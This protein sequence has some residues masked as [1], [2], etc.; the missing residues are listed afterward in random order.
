MTTTVPVT[1]K[2]TTLAE[3]I[4]AHVRDGMTV[5]L[6]GFSH[7]I[8]FAAAHEIIRQGRRDLTLCRM[9]PDIVSDQL[10]AAGC[11]SKL[12]ASFFA[13]GSAGSLHELRRRIERHDPAPLEVEEYSHYGM[14]CRY[15]AGAAGLP[16]FPLRSYAGSDLPELNPRIRLTT[17]PYTGDSVYV[18][19]PLTPDVTIIHAQRADRAGN[20][21]VWGITGVQQEAVYAA[22]T[23]IVLVEEIVDD[24]VVRSDP[25]RTL[26]P[27]HAVDAIV[28]CPRG[29][30]PSYAQGY[31]DRDCAFYRNWTPISKD[32]AA[33]QNWIDE[34]I[35]GTR[36]HEEYL[37]RL[38]DDHWAGLAVGSR[39]SG[40]VD[41][42]SRL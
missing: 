13:S 10:V 16:F 20:V 6:E 3:A 32:P 39:P 23:A 22:R 42:G 37:A 30:H 2:V 24:E 1:D 27:A 31:Y 41:Y 28:V 11:V 17:D 38:G 33:L 19:P 9:T 25:N 14:V 8:P 18:V 40:S 4:S 15:Q 7:L 21:Q 5:A 26:L 12:V 29:A 36:D 34:W 35:R